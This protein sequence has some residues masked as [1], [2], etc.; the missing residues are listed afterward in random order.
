MQFCAAPNQTAVGPKNPTPDFV[1]QNRVE[2]ADRATLKRPMEYD[3]STLDLAASFASLSMENNDLK[4]FRCREWDGK[5][6][7][8]N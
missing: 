8:V 5:A 2:F 3:K 6:K 4:L 1:N 7:I